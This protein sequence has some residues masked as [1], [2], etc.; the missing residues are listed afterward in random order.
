VDWSVERTSQCRFVVSASGLAAAHAEI[1]AGYGSVGGCLREGIGLSEVD[2][3]RLRDDLSGSF[4]PAPLD[5]PGS[6]AR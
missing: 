5:E 6:S 4:R 2:L 3:E 1:V